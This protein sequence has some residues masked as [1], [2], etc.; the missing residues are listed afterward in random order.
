MQII[1]STNIKHF[2]NDKMEIYQTLNSSNY[3][4]RWNVWLNFGCWSTNNLKAYR[5]CAYKRNLNIRRFICRN[6]WLHF[7]QWYYQRWNQ[8]ISNAHTNIIISFY[9]FNWKHLFEHIAHTDDKDPKFS[10]T[11]SIS[12]NSIWITRT[13]TYPLRKHLCNLGGLRPSVWQ[14]WKWA[15][16]HF[17]LSSD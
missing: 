5:D 4:K 17:K 11:A 8:Q 13:N 16:I 3:N 1:K 6:W 14:H 15:T 12:N 9:W 10:C 7:R 2:P